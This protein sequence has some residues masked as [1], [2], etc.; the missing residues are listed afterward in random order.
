MIYDFAD[1]AQTV[2][3]VSFPKK[4]FCLFVCLLEEKGGVIVK[5]AS[6]V[7]G[8]QLKLFMTLQMKHKLC[9]LLVFQKMFLFVCFLEEKGEG[10]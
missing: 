7:K 10:W 1:G 2:H 5:Q 8:L 4:M 9:T 6:I 3:T